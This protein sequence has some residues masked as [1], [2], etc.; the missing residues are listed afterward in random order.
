VR[1]ATACP[2]PI[3]LHLVFE[4]FLVF[5]EFSP[6][7]FGLQ[8][9]HDC[10]DER[11]RALRRAATNE[12]GKKRKAPLPVNERRAFFDGGV[13]LDDG[14]SHGLYFLEFLENKRQLRDYECC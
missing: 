9:E 5:E 10:S 12:A 2:H 1:S 4:S 11:N 6:I 8:A 7:D 14:L 13:R 3:K